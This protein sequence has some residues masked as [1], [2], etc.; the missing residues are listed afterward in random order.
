MKRLSGPLQGE[1]IVG[2]TRNVAFRSGLHARPQIGYCDSDKFG[3]DALELGPEN[4]GYPLMMG[5]G[6]QKGI[7]LGTMDGQDILKPIAHTIKTNKAC[8]Q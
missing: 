8:L 5:L 6:W 1:K 3:A 7:A 2:Y 4:K